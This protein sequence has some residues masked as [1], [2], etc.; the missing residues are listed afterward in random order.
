MQDRQLMSKELEFLRSQQTAA[1]ASS[2]KFA[3]DLD[4]TPELDLNVRT[5]NQ[6]HSYNGWIKVMQDEY[7]L[8]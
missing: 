1:M 4:M 6:S 3:V 8:K 7:D 2:R 5:E